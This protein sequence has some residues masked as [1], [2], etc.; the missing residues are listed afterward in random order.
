MLQ[1]DQT[2][3][4]WGWNSC[5]GCRQ[6]CSEHTLCR[7]LEILFK[8]CIFIFVF[9]LNVIINSLKILFCWPVSRIKSWLENLHKICWFY[10]ICFF[11]RV[12]RN[13]KTIHFLHWCHFFDSTGMIFGWNFPMF[14]Q[15]II[16]NQGIW[17]FAMKSHIFQ[18]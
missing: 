9:W 1:L 7:C 4:L 5:H 2:L 11:W 18:G 15:S 13:F 12:S 8:R 3:N 14:H 6:H 17:S 10:G 16:V